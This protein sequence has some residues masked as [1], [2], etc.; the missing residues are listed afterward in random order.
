[1]DE[2]LLSL[3]QG[4]FDT[5]AEDQGV[6]ILAAAEYG[7][8]AQGLDGPGSD[9]DIVFLAS[10]PPTWHA[11]CSD[12]PHRFRHQ[13]ILDGKELN[14]VGFSLKRFAREANASQP[15]VLT[16]V[17]AN[18]VWYLREEVATS[19]GR[20]FS[21][22]ED[23]FDPAPLIA[24]YRRLARDNRNAA[25]TADW[26]YLG[27]GGPQWTIR[28]RGGREYLVTGI[29]GYDEH[30]TKTP[31]DEA[32]GQGLLERTDPE[33]T[34]QD[35]LRIAR[36]LLNA[37]HVEETGKLPP[38]DFETLVEQRGTAQTN[39]LPSEVA[40]A[41]RD[42]ADRKRDGEGDET[43]GFVIGDWATSILDD[44]EFTVNEAAIRQ[45]GARAPDPVTINDCVD[46]TL[47]AIYW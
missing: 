47:R 3:A 17:N 31:V 23:N 4:A 42:L 26:E 8:H 27:A 14:L 29:L 32:I 24:H 13:E 38:F 18:Q 45:R 34:V 7:S 12:P 40:D 9:R 1:M 2:E 35:N 15:H 28:R 44:E 6:E 36:A 39:P 10:Y 20:L 16:F 43:V 33:P 11:H 37:H 5:L 19:I 46:E 21:H 22:L 25:T 30:E 41:L